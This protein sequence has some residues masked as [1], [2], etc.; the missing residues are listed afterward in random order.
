MNKWGAIGN[1]IKPM[2]N[3]VTR[4]NLDNK[5]RGQDKTNGKLRYRD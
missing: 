3:L 2:A 1:K 4:L 5:L